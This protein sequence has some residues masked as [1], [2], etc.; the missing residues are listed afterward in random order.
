M[1][2]LMTEAF[3]KLFS[4]FLVPQQLRCNLCSLGLH[5]ADKKGIEDHSSW[6]F[7]QWEKNWSEDWYSCWWMVLTYV[8]SYHPGT[9]QPLL[10]TLLLPDITLQQTVLLLSPC[11]T[12]LDQRNSPWNSE[13]NVSIRCHCMGYWG[14]SFNLIRRGGWKK[15][16]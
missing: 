13:L 12:N 8:E 2:T 16:C 11:A 15:W 7:L 5:F 14:H 4:M 9:D 10:E 1:R 6:N 3:L